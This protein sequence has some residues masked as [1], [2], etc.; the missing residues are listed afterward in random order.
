MVLGGWV[1]QLTT[2]NGDKF[3]PILAGSSIVS[4]SGPIFLSA[5]NILCNRWFG[6]DERGIATAITGL[7]IPLG[8]IMAFLQTGIVFTG[9]VDGDTED[10]IHATNKLLWQ[11]NIFITLMSIGFCLVIRDKPNS[12]PSVV[13][14]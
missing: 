6:D 11:Q 4:L 7:A 13:A 1:R 5:Q 14:M 2:F 8:S 9:I 12:P 10:T 3:W